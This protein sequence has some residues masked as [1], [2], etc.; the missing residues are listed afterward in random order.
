MKILL[1][2]DPEIPVPPVNYG[3]IE[4][5]VGGLIEEFRCLGHKVGFAGNR[6]S[7]V[8]VDYFIPWPGSKSGAKWDTV[9]NM[10][11]MV[12][13]VRQFQ[14]DLVHS[15]SRL[16]YMLP[17]MGSKLPKIMSYQ[18]DPSHN[19]V[20]WASRLSGKSL[21]FTGCSQF[22]SNLGQKSGGSW[23]TIPNFVDISKFDFNPKVHFDAPL[24]FL[25]RIEEIKGTH[26]AIEIAK[27]TGK[28]LIIAGNNSSDAKASEYWNQVILPRID[29]QQITYVGTVNDQEKNML[30]GSACA[31]IVPIQ[32]D[33][34]FGIV[35]AEALAC[36]T[37][38]ISCPRG[39]L[40]EIVSNV[41]AYS[42][43]IGGLGISIKDLV[44][45]VN[46]VSRFNR[47]SCR[48]YCEENF[49]LSKV[50]LKYLELYKGFIRP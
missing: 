50:A 27:Q 32:W 8:D 33:E 34:P 29:G 13:A 17:L 19:T 21:R 18:R 16:A 12:K 31:M 35:F 40:P 22:I 24:V 1:T 5:I 30:L 49:S 39:A 45:L 37:P 3:G 46:L 43:S 44:D 48:T 10:A 2:A 41:G 4:R 20:K 28:K 7:K 25:S 26:V 47:K 23:E 6:N 11:T 36:G 15:F 9:K 38:I 14:P 42:G